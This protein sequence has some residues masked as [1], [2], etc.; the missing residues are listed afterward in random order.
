[1]L[2]IIKRNW[3]D[4]W[5]FKVHTYIFFLAHCRVQTNCS[6]VL[7]VLIS[8][9]ECVLGYYLRVVITPWLPPWRVDLKITEIFFQ[10]IGWKVLVWALLDASVFLEICSHWRYWKK[11]RWGK[12]PLM[13]CWHI[14]SFWTPCW[15]FS[16]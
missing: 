3:M 13:K 1:M 12:Q 10:D 15:S 9:H 2:W 14:C 6:A 16:S 7:K 8:V 4:P 11:I 5:R